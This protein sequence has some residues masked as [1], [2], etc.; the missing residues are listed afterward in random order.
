VR[1]PADKTKVPHTL[2]LADDSVTIQRVIDLT[3]A[4]EDIDVVAVGDGDQ[5]IARI[6]ASPPDIILAD[7]GMPGKSGYEVAQYV[8]QS[9]RLSHIPV[10]LLTGA[11]EPVDQP[12][13]AAAGCEG[14]MVKPFEP[15]LVI[16]RVKELLAKSRVAPAQTPAQTPAHTTPLAARPETT[17]IAIPAPPPAVTDTA[18]PFQPAATLAAQPAATLTAQ[19]AATT[20]RP[21][22]PPAEHTLASPEPPEAA[23]ADL[24]NYFDRLDEAFANL[25]SAG[26]AARAEPVTKASED[27]DWFINN[28]A[29]HDAPV[30]PPGR[31]DVPARVPAQPDFP[32]SFASSRRDFDQ[33]AV[34]TRWQPVDNPEPIAPVPIP[35]PPASGEPATASSAPPT[36]PTLPSIGDAFAALLAAEQTGGSPPAALQWPAPRPVA[37]KTVDVVEEVTQ[38]VLDRLSDRV[39][40]ET[41]SG[42]VSGVA[43]RLVREEIDRIKASMK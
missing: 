9:P 42:I 11:F 7:I 1:F 20:A 40:R 16:G 8:K 5:A 28:D 26:P 3:F 41:V 37:A 21:P 36:P 35:Q 32:L 23:K 27:I 25:T 17:T 22:S 4:D 15:Q 33:P 43:E 29:D 19:P 34:A 31:H 13:A 2:L 24:N 39:V 18:I 6:E 12:R 14:V 30:A 38:R 10:L